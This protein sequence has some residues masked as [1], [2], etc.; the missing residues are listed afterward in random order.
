MGIAA[1]LVG[2]VLA[3]PTLKNIT[4]KGDDRQIAELRIMSASYRR[5]PDGTL[6]QIDEKT[7]PVQVTIWHEDTAKRVFDHIKVGA[8]VVVKGDLYVSPWLDDDRAPQAGVRIEAQSISL[9]LQRIEKIT[10]RARA[11]RDHDA[12]AYHSDPNHDP[13]SV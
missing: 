4:V 5:L 1:E 13:L 12:G 6:E 2:N 8:S 10:Y 9:N 7:F 11:P 3:A